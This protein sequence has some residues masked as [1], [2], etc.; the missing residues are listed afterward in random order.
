MELSITRIKNTTMRIF[1]I[2]FSDTE[3]IA[4]GP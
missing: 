2:L 1:Y 3:N 4:S